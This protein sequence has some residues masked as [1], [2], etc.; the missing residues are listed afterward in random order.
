MIRLYGLKLSNY[1][2]LTKA[3]LIEKGIEFEEVKTPPSQKE[4]F[5]Q[6]KPH[7]QDTCH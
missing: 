1:Y 2:S 4:D 6:K 7:G 5:L 3:L